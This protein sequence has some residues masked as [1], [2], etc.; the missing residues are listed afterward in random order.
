[1]APCTTFI[2]VES[3]SRLWHVALGFFPNLHMGKD[4]LF[5]NQD[6]KNPAKSCSIIQLLFGAFFVW[7]PFQIFSLQFPIRIAGSMGFFFRSFRIGRIPLDTSG[8]SDVFRESLRS[9]FSF[10]VVFISVANQDRRI[11]GI[12]FRSFTIARISLNAKS[13]SLGSFETVRDFSYCLPVLSRSLDH[14]RFKIPWSSQDRKDFLW[15]FRISVGTDLD[16]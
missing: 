9:F 16:S 5:H 11:D 15:S 8:F 1:M 12:F 10:S 4:S 7:D 2:S 3:C 6:R 13:G 14:R